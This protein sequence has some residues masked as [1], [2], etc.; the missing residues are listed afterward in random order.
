LSLIA[1]FALDRKIKEACAGLKPAA[2]WALKELPRDE[3]KGLIAN[4]IINWSNDSNDGA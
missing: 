1:I 3:D 4:F 2:Q